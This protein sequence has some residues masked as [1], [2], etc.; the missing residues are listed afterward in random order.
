MLEVTQSIKSP[1]V[2]A[3]A[4]KL[5]V[6]LAVAVS[7]VP[8]VVV[9]LPLAGKRANVP[10]VPDFPGVGVDATRAGVAP[11]IISPAEP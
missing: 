3:V 6:L 4:K 2:G 11:A 5:T 7:A 10:A 1:V 9:K 8:K